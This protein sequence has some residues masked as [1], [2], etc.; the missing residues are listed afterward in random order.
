MEQVLQLNR[1][2]AQEKRDALLLLLQLSR[3]ADASGE[4]ILEQLALNVESEGNELPALALPLE[5]YR[6]ALARGR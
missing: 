6:N 5:E 4:Q 2:E 3:N 1:D